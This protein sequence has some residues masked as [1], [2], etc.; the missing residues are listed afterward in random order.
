[1]SSIKDRLLSK[2]VFHQ[3]SSSIVLIRLNN[4]SRLNFS[5]LQSIELAQKFASDALAVRGEV[6]VGGGSGWSTVI[7]QLAEPSYTGTEAE[8]GNYMLYVSAD[9]VT[10]LNST[11]TIKIIT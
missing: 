7:I 1:M 9:F 11:T 5:F 2:V 3:R 8:L 10:T 4:P 6:A